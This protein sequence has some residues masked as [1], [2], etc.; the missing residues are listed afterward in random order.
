MAV[1][2]MGQ[3]SGTPMLKQY[4]CH[5]Q[6]HA[7]KIARVVPGEIPVPGGKPAPVKGVIWIEGS[8]DPIILDSG[9]FAKHAP[10]AGG[11]FVLYEDGYQSY[12]PA[13]AFEKGYTLVAENDNA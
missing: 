10:R 13:E 1:G 5:K 11:Y 9:Y 2:E 8:P 3:V 12:S 7:G 4:Q 6:V